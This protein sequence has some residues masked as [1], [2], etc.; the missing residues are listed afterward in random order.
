MDDNLKD[1]RLATDQVRLL[2][3]HDHASCMQLCIMYLELYR[4]CPGGQE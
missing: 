3:D 2:Y 4:L 1:K